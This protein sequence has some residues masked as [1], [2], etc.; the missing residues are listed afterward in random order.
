MITG[1]AGLVGQNLLPRLKAKHLGEIVAIDKHRTNAEIL[2][3]HH[4]EIR[5][6]VEDLAS[7]DA[8]QAE[9]R[10]APTW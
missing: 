3:A 2:R 7:S 6:L 5:V 1:A 4:P 10:V 9:L 8:W